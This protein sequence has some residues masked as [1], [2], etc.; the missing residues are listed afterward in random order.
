M[1]KIGAVAIS[2]ANGFVGRNV[3]RYL[4]KEGFEITSIIREHASRSISRGSHVI[5]EDLTE[6]NLPSS[7]RGSM[8][9]LHFI[10]EGRQDVESDFEKVNHILTRNAVRLCKKSGIKKIVYMSGLGVSSNATSGYFISKFKAEQ[11]IIRSG[12]DYT[13][14][15]ASYIIGGSDPLS[16]VLRKQVR[17]GN[18]DIPGSGK[19][20]IQP[21]FIEDVAK[22]I[23]SSI[24]NKKFS[25]K[26]IDLVGPRV[27]TYKQFVRDLVRVKKVKVHSLDF[28]KL[29]HDALICKEQDFGV[30]DL[31]IIVGDYIGNHDMLAR[32]SGIKFTGYGDMLE[33]CR[34]S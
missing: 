5:S 21:I 15:R 3:S 27:V 28:E 13:I 8:A 26:T 23:L 29:Y 6:N 31:G 4:D 1:K 10:G 25:R 12:L 22:T 7:I 16:K 19:Y 18:I 2:G 24:T 11:E 34:L 33:A 32:V 17:R 9:F 20:R 30:D 14:F